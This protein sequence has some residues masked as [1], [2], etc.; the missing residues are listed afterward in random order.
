MSCVLCVIDT[1]CMMWP[2]FDCFSLAQT[3]SV[4]CAWILMRLTVTVLDVHGNRYFLLN[5]FAIGFIHDRRSFDTVLGINIVTNSKLWF[6]FHFFFFFAQMENLFWNWPVRRMAIVVD[7][8]RYREKPIG[9]QRCHRQTT[10]RWITTKMR[11]QR[12]WAVSIRLSSIYYTYKWCK[13]LSHL[14]FPMTIVRFSRHRGNEI[15][16]GSNHHRVEISPKSFV[17]II[18]DRRLS[19]CMQN[20]WGYRNWSLVGRTTPNCRSINE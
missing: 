7:G 1:T 3:L 16:A 20:V 5:Y 14:Q 6:S 10:I 2:D 4:Q 17:C 9:H 8:Y 13:L 12:H 11:V 18:T 19:F 15:I